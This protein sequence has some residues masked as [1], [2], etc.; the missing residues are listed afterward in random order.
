MNLFQAEVEMKKRKE[1]D[2]VDI[3]ITF[4]R[5]VYIIVHELV[6]KMNWR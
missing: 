6:V 5:E 1:K 4:T 2:W 3:H